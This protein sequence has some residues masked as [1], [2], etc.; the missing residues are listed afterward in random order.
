MFL[1]IKLESCTKQK[2]Y[3]TNF[4]KFR[5]KKSQFVSKKKGFTFSAIVNVKRNAPEKLDYRYS[6]ITM[7]VF[8]DVISKLNSTE[9]QDSNFGNLCVKKGGSLQKERFSFILHSSMGVG[10]NPPQPPR[11]YATG[12]T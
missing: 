4:G 8:Q 3:D 9:K 5:T 6:F 1:E 2:K 12:Y 7:K 10:L 11:A